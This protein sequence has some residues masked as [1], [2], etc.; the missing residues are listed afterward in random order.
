M[1]NQ[2]PKVA[3]G[4][5][6]PNFAV[7]PIPIQSI[8]DPRT[9]DFAEIGSVWI[10]SATNNAWMLTSVVNNIAVWQEI[11]NAGGGGGG[12]LTWHIEPGPGPV[13]MAPNSG[14]YL[15][16][17]GMTGLV[18]PLISALG[19]QIYIA[20]ADASV[21]GFGFAV[22]QNA[23]QYILNGA[24]STT[25]GIVG[26][27]QTVGVLPRSMTMILI[28]TVANTEW[29]MFVENNVNYNCV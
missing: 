17:A 10:N 2:R 8:R 27:I 7:G 29:T 16:G 26:G 24:N 13:A 28:C 6:Q 3:Y 9:S 18:L 12:G 14:Y 5:S 1:A 4:L 22:A 19:A 20:T 21:F 25:P 23:G 11:D 15:T